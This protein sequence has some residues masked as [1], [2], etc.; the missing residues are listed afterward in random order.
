MARLHELS[1]EGH[2]LK[3]AIGAAWVGYEEGG[4]VPGPFEPFEAV[5]AAE[6]RT[7][8]RLT[9]EGRELVVLSVAERLWHR[10]WRLVVELGPPPTAG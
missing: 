4:D 2:A 5:T 6:Y 8:D 3:Q 1:A 7:G 10:D 9:I